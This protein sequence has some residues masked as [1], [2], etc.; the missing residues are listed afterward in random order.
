MACEAILAVTAL[1]VVLFVSAL[2]LRLAAFAAS[3]AITAIV[4]CVVII[5]VA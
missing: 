2:L 1:I 4:A 5:F 3:R